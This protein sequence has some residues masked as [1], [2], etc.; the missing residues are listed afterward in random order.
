[1]TGQCNHTTPLRASADR[2]APIFNLAHG[3]TGGVA[4]LIT[5]IVGGAVYRGSAI[6]EL[7]GAYLFAEFYPNRPVRA[8]YQCGDETSPVTTISKRCD[9]NTPDAPCFVPQNGAPE[10][11]QVGAIAYGNDGELY[12]PANGNGILQVG[13]V[14]PRGRRLSG[15]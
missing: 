2:R 9:P 3:S 14:P 5:T 6:P 13:P 1:P 4:N 12:S 10:L 15:C 7:R 8:L 11:R